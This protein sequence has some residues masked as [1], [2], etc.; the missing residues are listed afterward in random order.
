MVAQVA[1][2]S[3]A[4]SLWSSCYAYLESPRAYFDRCENV[5]PSFALT[6]LWK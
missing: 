4:A 3:L 5:G 2:V 1:I 6:T